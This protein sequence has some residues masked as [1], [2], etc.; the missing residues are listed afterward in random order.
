MGESPCGFPA[1]SDTNT[2]DGLGT[3]RNERS[4]YGEECAMDEWKDWNR[5]RPLLYIM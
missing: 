2:V 1:R 3:E 4:H 5:A